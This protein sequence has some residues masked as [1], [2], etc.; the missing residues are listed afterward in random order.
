MCPSR[1]LACD[2]PCIDP[3]VHSVDGSLASGAAGA[4]SRCVFAA[5]GAVLDVRT[6]ITT[7]M[8]SDFVLRALD[9]VPLAGAGAGHG[10]DAGA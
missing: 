6:L 3:C 7:D 10:G 5:A 8:G 9:D 1:V 4:V 2:Q